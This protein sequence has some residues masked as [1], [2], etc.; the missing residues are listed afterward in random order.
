MMDK[1]RKFES[2]RTIKL[3]GVLTSIVFFIGIVFYVLNAVV[4]NGSLFSVV[5]PVVF[6]GIG[7][8][9][10]LNPTRKIFFIYVAAYSLYFVINVGLIFFISGFEYI[11]Q[12]VFEAIWLAYFIFKYFRIKDIMVTKE[13]ILEYDESVKAFDKNDL[14]YLTVT[15]YLRTSRWICTLYEDCILIRRKY[16]FNKM[17]VDKKKFR[18]DFGNL[19]SNILIGYIYYNEKREMCRM[20][21]SEYDAYRKL[22]KKKYVR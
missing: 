7:I 6:F 8:F 21:K 12:I 9:M 11:G 1:I 13:D 19:N 10:F 3:A 5:F 20:K 22:L 15:N 16:K 14:F 2:I 18:F 17:L 4:Y